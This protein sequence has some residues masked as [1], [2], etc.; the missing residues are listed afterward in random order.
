L[1]FSTNNRAMHDRYP[2]NS[3]TYGEVVTKI[4]SLFVQLTVY[5]YN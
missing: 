4:V 5:R 2:R 3:S 1:T